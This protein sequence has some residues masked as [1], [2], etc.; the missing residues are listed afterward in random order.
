MKKLLF[1]AFAFALL[2]LVFPFATIAAEVAK[3][4]IVF[5]LVD[6]LGYGELGCFG[7]KVMKTP[8]LDS[9]ASQ[10]MRLTRFYS[11]NT[12]CAPSRTVLMTG[13]HNGHATI[14]GNRK[15]LAPGSS[16][17]AEEPTV[18]KLLQSAGYRTACIG[19][20][21]LGTEKTSGHPDK[22]GFEEFFGFLTHRHAHNHFPDFVWR[23]REKVHLKNE[24]RSISQDPDDPAGVPTKAVEYVD[25][26][27]LKDA[28]QFVERNRESPFFLYYS[29]TIP[30]ANNEAAAVSQDGNE[31]PEYGSYAARDWNTPQKGH[32]AMVEK[33][34][35][36]VGALLNRLKELGIAERTLVLF[37][38]DNG[39]HVEGGEGS[40]DIFH[41]N[42][43]L[44]GK[45][46]DLTEGGIRV[47]TIAW[48]P[49]RIAPGSESDHVAYFGDFLS[50]AAEIAGVPVPAGRDGISF[51]PTLT[52][53]GSQARHAHLYWEFH[54]KGFS[55]AVLMDGQWKAIRMHEKS[56][57]LEL[58]DLSEDPGETRNV[59]QAHPERVARAEGLFLSEHAHSDAWRPVY[60]LK[61]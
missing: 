53:R 28:L 25:D 61:K 4:N 40:V 20:W 13:L 33:M 36:Y 38:S 50:S 7:Q 47:P 60:P 10:G 37:S 43:S 31:V 21:G 24:V 54:E 6:D 46:R 48:W 17:N 29:M 12:V 57:P 59:A 58:Y 1:H 56:A 55:Q 18:A 44:R 45:K 39:H 51:V 49:G 32:A 42:G 22:Q 35:A 19:K 11:G 8:H 52:R 23:G 16:L 41:K 15:P 27:F 14:R 34:D 2:L 30:H 9:M 3:P 26:L 5:V